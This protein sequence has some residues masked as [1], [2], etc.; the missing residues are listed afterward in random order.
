MTTALLKSEYGENHLFISIEVGLEFK[1]TTSQSIEV[2]L[3]IQPTCINYAERLGL[4]VIV[5]SLVNVY[6]D[7][8]VFTRIAGTS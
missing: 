8:L 1:L 7:L 2:R 5:N 4:N 3:S 6:A